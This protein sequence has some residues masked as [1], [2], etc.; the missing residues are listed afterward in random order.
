MTQSAEGPVQLF[1]QRYQL[2][3]GSPARGAILLQAAFFEPTTDC[4]SVCLSGTRR[5]KERVG[6]VLQVVGFRGSLALTTLPILVPSRFLPKLKE[7]VLSS[8]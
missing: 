7:R 6:T 1:N 5:L 4:C 2:F 3:F 8:H